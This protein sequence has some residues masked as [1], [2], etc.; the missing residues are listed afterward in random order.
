MN[1]RL[2]HYLVALLLHAILFSFIFVGVQCSHTVQPPMA[3]QGTIVNP[4][5]IKQQQASA[6]KQRTAEKDKVVEEAR[7]QAAITAESE[8]REKQQAQ[9]KQ[10]QTHLKM[11]QEARQAAE[12]VKQQAQKLAQRK[13]ALQKRAEAQQKVKAERQAQLKA[14]QKAALQKRVEAQQKVEA[15]R[16]AQLKAQR[17]AAEKKMVEEKAAAAAAK[18]AQQKKADEAA[19]RKKAQQ[20]AA[21][22]AKRKAAEAIKQ[23]A[24][25]EAKAK[26]TAAKKQEAE[27]QAELKKRAAELQQLL[28]TEAQALKQASQN[29]WVAAI[30]SKLASNWLRPQGISDTIICTV[31]VELAG[32]GHVLSVQVIKSSGNSLFDDSVRRAVLKSDPLPLP[33]DPTAFQSGLKLHFTPKD[34]QNA[35]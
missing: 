18:Q 22:A 19:A 29:A 12:Q 10:Q 6:E 8:L 14:Q 5:Q 27:K 28:G 7:R 11:Q 9:L 15:E 24:E 30:R 1:L 13:A 35:G 34:L 23:K 3:I 20:E 16:Q 2:R 17:Q 26:A 25:Q 31:R 4:S 32:N 33:V 21:A